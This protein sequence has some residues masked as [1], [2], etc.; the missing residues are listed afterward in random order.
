MIFGHIRNRICALFGGLG[1]LM[2]GCTKAKYVWSTE[3]EYFKV[4]IWKE[5]VKKFKKIKAQPHTVKLFI[6]DS[7]TEGF[8]LDRHLKTDSLVNMGISGDMTSGILKR[9]NL[10]EKLQPKKI[11]IM[12]GINDIRMKIPIE[13]IQTQYAEIIQSLKLSC[14]KSEIYVQSVLPARGIDGTDMTNQIV[15]KSVRELNDFL[16]QKCIE[17]NVYYVRLYPLFEDPKDFLN[18]EFTYDG[19]HLNDEGYRFWSDQIASF[20][21]D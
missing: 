2:T 21:T 8:D 12:V 17:L 5:H 19:I 18:S 9:L 7:I 13:R 11:F 14:P 1:I 15:G 16:E 4:P 3:E 6:G 10:V 20:L